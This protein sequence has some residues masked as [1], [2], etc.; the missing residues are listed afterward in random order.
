M[1]AA[2]LLTA[3]IV[4]QYGNCDWRRQQRDAAKEGP[5]TYRVLGGAAGKNV[6]GKTDVEPTIADRAAMAV[7]PLLWSA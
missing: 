1:S 5:G 2:G 7:F 4:D 3:F 6:E